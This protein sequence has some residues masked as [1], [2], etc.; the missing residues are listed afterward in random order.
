MTGGKIRVSARLLASVA[1]PVC[2]LVVWLLAVRAELSLAVSWALLE[3]AP[4]HIQAH[5]LFLK[6]DNGSPRISAASSAQHPQSS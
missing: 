6:P 2:V 4:T 1:L 3:A 5:G